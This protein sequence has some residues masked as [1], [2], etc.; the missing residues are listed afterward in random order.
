MITNAVAVG[1]PPVV[2]EYRECYI[3]PPLPCCHCSTGLLVPGGF[4]TLGRIAKPFLKAAAVFSEIMEYTGRVRSLGKAGIPRTGVFRKLP[5]QRRDIPQ[6][7][8]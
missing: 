3:R 8:G 7:I 2:T 6:V 5:R 4:S 1:D